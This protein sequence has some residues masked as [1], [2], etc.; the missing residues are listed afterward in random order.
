MV[1]P[2]IMGW[3]GLAGSIISALLGLGQFLPASVAAVLTVAG[4]I[5]TALSKALTDTDGDG[6]PG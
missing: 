5:V 6:L 4:T 2:K 3:L 1:L